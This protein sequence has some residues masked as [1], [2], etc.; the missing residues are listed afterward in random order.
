MYGVNVWKTERASWRAVVQ[1]NL[2]HSV[3]IILDVLSKHLSKRSPHPSAQGLSSNYLPSPVSPAEQLPFRRGGAI[4]FGPAPGPGQVSATTSELSPDAPMR[5]N[6]THRALRLR[7]APL[8]RVEAD[9]CARLGIAT[10]DYS[11]AGAISPLAP[12]SPLSPEASPT[13]SEKSKEIAVRSWKNALFS[14]SKLAR[15]MR[16]G[17]AGVE[18]ESDDTT[19]VLVQ[20]RDDINAL[21]D[22]SAIQQ[23]LKAEEIDLELKPGL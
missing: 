15:S 14:N 1:L 11:S 4:P 8:R 20:C 9:L 7:L 3:N 19:D 13:A 5:F 18:G 22:D 21:W 16:G 6:D 2:I 23:M 17:R 12:P 10:E